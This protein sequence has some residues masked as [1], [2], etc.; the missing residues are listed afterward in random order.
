MSTIYASS[1]SLEQFFL[2]KLNVDCFWNFSHLFLRH[3]LRVPSG[4][5]YLTC[6]SQVMTHILRGSEEQAAALAAANHCAMR[7]KKNKK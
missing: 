4:N 6:H 1:W 5:P 3:E 2:T 7:N